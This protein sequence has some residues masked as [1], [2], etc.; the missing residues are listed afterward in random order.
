[1]ASFL[2]E[3]L[4]VFKQLLDNGEA[5]D[6]TAGE[7]QLHLPFIRQ[8]ETKVML[9]YPTTRAYASPPGDAS[10][11]EDELLSAAVLFGNASAIDFSE[12]SMPVSP[13]QELAD[14]LSMTDFPKT[15]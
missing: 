15:T 4:F 3:Y 11:E 12:L 13:A 10:G 14:F 7:T 5:V 1:M 9:G 6:S 8:N 2:K